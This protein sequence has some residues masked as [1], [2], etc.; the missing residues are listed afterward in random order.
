MASGVAHV[1]LLLDSGS[2]AV[3]PRAAL[4]AVC[5]VALAAAFTDRSFSTLSRLACPLPP[6]SWPIAWLAMALTSARWRK[7][8]FRKLR[9]LVLTV[10]SPTVRFSRTSVPPAALMAAWAASAE[11]P[12]A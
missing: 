2:L 5:A 1:P 8:A 7:T 9:L 10:A 4:V 3:L 6:G 12:L 11:A